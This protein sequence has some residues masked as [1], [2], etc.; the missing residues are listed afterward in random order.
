MVV[1]KDGDFT[2]EEA[3]LYKK[4]KKEGLLI[5]N[6]TKYKTKVVMQHFGIK[7]LSNNS[8]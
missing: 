4:I 2:E 1:M 7:S 6:F 3:N 8:S 5:T